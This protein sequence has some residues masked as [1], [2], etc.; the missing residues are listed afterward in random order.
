MTK[1]IYH[2]GLSMRQI[3]LFL[4]ATG[5]R[6]VLSIRQIR[7]FLC[8]TGVRLFLSAT[9]TPVSLCDG[10]TPVSIGD[11]YACFFVL[12]LSL[13]ATGVCLFLLVLWRLVRCLSR[14]VRSTRSLCDAG[15]ETNQAMTD[16]RAPL[17]IASQKGH[18]EVVRCLCD[19]GSAP[20]RY[21]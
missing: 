6:L 1:P 5:V 3:R 11:R 21:T 8:A 20:L 15:A 4:R 12:R 19:A 9:A 17:F 2:D 18:L 16:G 10:S 7:L 14:L 13:N